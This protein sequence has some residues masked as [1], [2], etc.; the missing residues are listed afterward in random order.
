MVRVTPG[1]KSLGGPASLSLSRAGE[2]VIHF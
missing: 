1:P 2:M